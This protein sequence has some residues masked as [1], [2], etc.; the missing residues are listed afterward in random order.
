MNALLEKVAAKIDTL[1][2]AERDA[3]S[4]DVTEYAETLLEIRGKL[5]EGE[6]SLKEHGGIPAEEV[7]AELKQ[8]YAAI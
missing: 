5:A 2:P 7:F 1:P 3:V 8:R 6:K 4:A